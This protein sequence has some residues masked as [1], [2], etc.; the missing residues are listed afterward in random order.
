MSDRNLQQECQAES[1]GE[2][3]EQIMIRG[4]KHLIDDPLHEEWSDQK[5]YL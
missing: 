1:N 2:D 4:Y 5:E 3:G